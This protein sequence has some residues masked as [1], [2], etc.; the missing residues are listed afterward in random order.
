MAPTLAAAPTERRS[1]RTG[2]LVVLA[3]LSC[4]VLA[5]WEPD[6]LGFL[7]LSAPRR[8][9]S[10]RPS[11]GVALGAEGD[12]SAALEG[13]ATAD[14]L[15]LESPTPEKE[16]VYGDAAPP[17]NIPLFQELNISAKTTPKGLMRA[18]VGAFNNGERA[19]DLV[20][21]DPR[22]KHIFLYSL[23]LLPAPFRASGQVLIRRRDRRL[24]M[25]VVQRF[26]PPED[27]APEVFRVASGS[28]I[29]ALGQLVKNIFTDSLGN[30]LKRT[31]QLEFQGQVCAGNAVL[32]IEHA[33]RLAFRELFFHARKVTEEIPS[34]EPAGDQDAQT[35]PAAPNKNVFILVTI[36]TG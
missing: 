21:T 7:G 1:R 27:E 15:A 16:P 29:T 35:A 12:V 36:T 18:M 34:S 3:V 2:G 13:D 14:D 6:V 26:R 19:V 8:S 5:A 23:A 20:L 30:N 31:V 10:P 17:P 25:R 24:R 11:W 28:N 32:V 33:E 9:R 4:G 22:H